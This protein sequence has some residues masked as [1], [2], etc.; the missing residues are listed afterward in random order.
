D[1]NLEMAREVL[2]AHAYWRRCGL[3]AD[4]VLLHD[5]AGDELRGGL[6]ERGENAPTAE[7]VDKPGGVFLRDASRMSADDTILLE[8]AARLILHGGDGPLGAQLRRPLPRPP[9]PA[10]A[11]GPLPCLRRGATAAARRQRSP[12]AR[13]KAARLCSSTMVLAGSPRMAGS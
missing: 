2:R 6:E 5:G 4:L 1:G 9:P 3:V 10:P 7:L 8:A 13:R 11:R 12:G